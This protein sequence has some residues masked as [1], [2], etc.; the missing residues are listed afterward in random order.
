MIETYISVDIE[1]SGPIP[2]EY[3]MLAIGACLVSA[4]HRDFYTE[5]RPLNDRYVPEAL[6]VSG[7][8][9]GKL[10]EEGEEPAVAMARFE[11]W[12][13][14][15][16]PLGQSPV[17]VAF[18]A[19]FD[20]MFTHYYFMRFLG[21]DPFG[22]SGLDIKAFYMGVVGS[23]WA[24]TSKGRIDKRFVPDRPHTHHALEDAAWQAELFASLLAHQRGQSDEA[25]G[26]R[27]A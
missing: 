5:L 26:P 21:R 19:T 8:S 17:F 14:Q 23:S 11:Q 7:L 2:G 18:N 27:P 3:S 13:E 15:M 24:A 12:L 22:V 6:A 20:W 1:A 10:M 4:P 9:L 16:T 25:F